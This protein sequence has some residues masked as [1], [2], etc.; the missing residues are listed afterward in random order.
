LGSVFF[1]R[2]FR[3]V[4][5]GN[6]SSSPSLARYTSSEQIPGHVAVRVS[7]RKANSDFFTFGIH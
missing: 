7:F 1:F 3:V 4:P 2:Y 6:R 5:H